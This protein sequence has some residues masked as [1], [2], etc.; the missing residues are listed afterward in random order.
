MQ[1]KIDTDILQEAIRVILRLSPPVS[2][3]VTINSDGRSLWLHSAAELSRCSVLI[4]CTVTGKALFA[5]PTQSL[6]DA[7][8]GHAT[9]DMVYDKTMLTLKGGR[10]KASLTTVDAL[11]IEENDTAEEEKGKKWKVTVDQLQ[12]LKSAVSAVALKPTQNVTT[13]MPVSV[14]LTSK[15]A[16]VSCYDEQHMAFTSSKEITGDLE[17]LLPI[18]TLNNVLDAFSKVSCVMIVTASSLIVRNKLVSVVLAL[19]EIENE[20]TIRDPE[21]VRETARE[22]MKA[23]GTGIELDKK[24]LSGFLDNCRAVAT[25]E[26]PELMVAT[27]Q[28]KIRFEV[29]TTN[30]VVNT[31]MPSGIQKSVRFK[32]DFEFFDEAVRKCSDQVVF[33][34][35]DDSFLTF[36]TKNTNLLVAL[37]QDEDAE[38]GTD[39]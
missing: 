29:K 34:L 10:Y 1:A 31:I 6:A 21:Q 5:I 15:S 27:K 2:G 32:I 3:N 36:K 24:A 28:G 30:G 23:D 14:K 13:F 7:S 18:E 39:E 22:A 16:F 33:K 25:K 38:G 12:W 20:N 9:L 26:R 17:L 8:K 4:P 37:N 11:Q 19:P 35:V